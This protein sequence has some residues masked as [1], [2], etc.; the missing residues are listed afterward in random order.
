MT[1]VQVNFA[2]RKAMEQFD[3]W[4]DVSGKFDVATGYYGEIEGVIHDAVH[5]GIQ[6]ALNGKIEFDEEGN[7]KIAK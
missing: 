4:N 7:V 1:R 6:M 5:I 2:E 3:R